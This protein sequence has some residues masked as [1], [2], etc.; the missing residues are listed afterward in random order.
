M[1]ARKE[2]PVLMNTNQVLSSLKNIYSASNPLAKSKTGLILAT[3]ELLML[4]NP[5]A[6]TVVADNSSF[7]SSTVT[8]S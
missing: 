2:S 3:F 7:D 6:F 4:I 5:S 1:R 8:F